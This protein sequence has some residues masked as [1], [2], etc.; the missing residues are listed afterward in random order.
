MI[1]IRLPKEIDNRLEAL[2]YKTGRTKT[3]YA[4]EAILHYLEDLE[5]AYLAMER[6]KKPVKR[7][8]TEEV[9]K[10]LGLDS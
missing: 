3:Y 7:M 6:I 9:I 4:K 1:A 10:E 2:A 8:S 5:D